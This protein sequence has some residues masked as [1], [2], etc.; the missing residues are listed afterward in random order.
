M[1]PLLLKANLGENLTHLLNCNARLSP[2]RGRVY[3]ISMG[4]IVSGVGLDAATARSARFGQ[5]QGVILRFKHCHLLIHDFPKCRRQMGKG[6][7]SCSLHQR[8]LFGPF[9]LSHAVTR[10]L[11][12]VHGWV[13]GHLVGLG[14]CYGNLTAAGR[15]RVALDTR[16]SCYHTV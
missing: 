3:F 16:I 7:R 5:R 10:A 14:A 2:A 8:S 4:R 6:H 12:Y 11:R 13:L 9:I 15:P 1:G